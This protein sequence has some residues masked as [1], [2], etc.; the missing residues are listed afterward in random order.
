MTRLFKNFV[1]VQGG[2]EETVNLVIEEDRIRCLL[3]AEQL[4]LPGGEEPDTIVDLGGGYLCHG[5]IDMHV[6]GGGGH[7]FMDNTVEAYRAACD[8]HLAHGTTALLPT[9]VA[10]SYEKLAASLDTY[11]RAE[12]E[13]A[14]PVRLLGMHI[15]GPYLAVNQAGAQDPAF[16]R[17]PDPAE[18][19]SLIKRYPFIKR[20]TVAP[21]RPGALA[22]GDF[23]HANGIIASAGHSDATLEEMKLAGQHGFKLLTH[24]YS[25]MSTIVRKGG[26]RHPG[27]IESAYLLDEVAVEIIADGYHLPGSLLEMVRRFIGSGRTALITDAMRGAGMPE[28]PSILGARDGGLPVILEGGVAKLPDR[29][30]FAGSMATADRLLETMVNQGKSTLAE[31]VQMMTETPARIMGLEKS[32][33]S[34]LPGRAADLCVFKFNKN[35]FTVEQVYIGGECV[36][37]KNGV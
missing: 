7:D 13:S 11:E 32:I 35:K 36:W 19:E 12:Q 1:L 18:Y 4:H 28:G 2:R 14:S 8:T 9:T 34:V 24:L 23:L 27:L 31:A 26:F 22:M 5:F 16:I 21:E 17:D 30:A 29:S 37:Q 10:S 20:W 25:A 33:G 15:E 3:P 6:H